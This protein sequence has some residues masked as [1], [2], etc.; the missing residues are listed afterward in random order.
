M[1][2][3]ILFGGMAAGLSEET[4]SNTLIPGRLLRLKDHLKEERN[5]YNEFI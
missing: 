4:G 5:F 3:I 1:K 2:I